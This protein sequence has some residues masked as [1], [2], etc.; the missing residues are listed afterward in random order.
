M[1]SVFVD[2]KLQRFL[3]L[4]RSHFRPRRECTQ[5]VL[6][7]L[8]FPNV[9]H[10]E[11]EQRVLLGAADCDAGDSAAIGH[12]E[13]DLSGP[14]VGTDLNPAAS[15]DELAAFERVAERF[16][17]SV[18]VPVGDVQREESL[19]VGERAVVVDLVAIDPLRMTFGDREQ[20]LIGAIRHAG[21]EFD[22]KSD[23]L[24]N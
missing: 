18:V 24:S 16:G 1:K 8:A 20:L 7:D 2:A 4:V 6:L 14:I 11:G 12:G 3:Q 17:V 21:R 23:A 10:A 13:D 15:G 19:L 9:L 22:P 5:R